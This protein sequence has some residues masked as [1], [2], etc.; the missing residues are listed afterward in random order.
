M[1][2]QAGEEYLLKQSI[3]G[4]LSG[5][6]MSMGQDS[7]NYFP[8]IVPLIHNSVK[9]DSETRQYLLEEALDLWSSVLEHTSQPCPPKI[10]GLATNL[11]P[12]F[13]SASDA[14]IKALEITEA[15]IYL[16]PNEMLSS[17]SQLFSAWNPL[18]TSLKS[19]GALRVTNLI[20]LLIRQAYAVGAESTVE[21]LSHTLYEYNIIN[22]WLLGL[23]SAH[24]A[25][26]TTGP[27][28]LDSQIDPQVETEYLSMLGRLAIAS[29]ELLISMLA[30]YDTECGSTG[31]DTLHWLM[32]EWFSHF[33]NLISPDRKKLSCLALTALLNSSVFPTMLKNL[34]L[35]MSIQT[36]TITELL[37]AD[38]GADCLIMWP[39]GDSTINDDGFKE[40]NAEVLKRE[41]LL[42]DPVRRIDVKAYVRENLG[43]AIAKCGSET[44]FREQWLVNVDQD[45]V[46]AFGKLG[47][48]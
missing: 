30:T 21:R 3:L 36:D 29:P 4:I 20:E 17:G 14:L 13:D 8:L 26:Q 38:T 48:L 19:S 27:N 9:P 16:I 1:W 39:R 11:F 2:D 7:Q 46:S 28:R 44:A 10:T 42:K 32:E 31:G 43:V 22:T 15:Y 6:V 18:L 37:D 23:K 40:S 35:L 34:Q 47:V 12:M 24:S 41:L 5:I 33:D 25:H 45:V